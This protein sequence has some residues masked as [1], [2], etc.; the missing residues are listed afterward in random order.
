MLIAGRIFFPYTYLNK[1]LGE[2]K[3]MQLIQ[4]ETVCTSSLSYHL[5]YQAEYQLI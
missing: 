5:W 4:N 2:A 3:A 1:D